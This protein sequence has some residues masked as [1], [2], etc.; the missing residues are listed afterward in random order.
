MYNI[1]GFDMYI[2]KTKNKKGVP[3]DFADASKL[4]PMEQICFYYA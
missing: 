3:N 4:I 2:K 1:K